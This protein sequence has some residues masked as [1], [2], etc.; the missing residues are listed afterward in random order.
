MTRGLNMMNKIRDLLSVLFTVC[1][2][3]VAAVGVL[4]CVCGCRPYVVMS[5]SMEPGIPTG[6]LVWINEN[7]RDAAVGDVIAF[8]L[9]DIVVTH[10]VAGVDDG[11]NLITKGDANVSADLSPVPS[12]SVVGTYLL[13]IPKVGY[14]VAAVQDAVRWRE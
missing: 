11:G 14:V 6:S 12:S 10:R 8:R 5:G 7:R 1:L 9:G 13:H 2:S 3:V 4:S